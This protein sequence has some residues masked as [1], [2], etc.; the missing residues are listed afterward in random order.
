MRWPRKYTQL[1]FASSSCAH[2]SSSISVD[3]VRKE[4]STPPSSAVCGCCS[5]RCCIR[6]T[7]RSQP[8]SGCCAFLQPSPRLAAVLLPSAA[9][10]AAS[11]PLRAQRRPPTVRR[12]RHLTFVARGPPAACSA[13]SFPAAVTTLLRRPRRPRPTM[14]RLRRGLRRPTPSCAPLRPMSCASTAPTPPRTRPTTSAATRDCS[15]SRSTATAPTP[16]RRRW[17]PRSRSRCATIRRLGCALRSARVAQCRADV[18]T[19]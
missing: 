7:L 11:Q 15:A 9:Q 2:A 1:L 5:A 8:T 14:T 12:V 19:R 3:P 10:S 18:L 4:D 13:A 16:T 17:R 6:C